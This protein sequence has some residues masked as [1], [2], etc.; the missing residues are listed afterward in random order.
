VP[1]PAFVRQI[2]THLPVPVRRRVLP[3]GW[4][5]YER[6]RSLGK[7]S[8]TT[9]PNALELGGWPLPPPRLRVLVVGETDVQLF[10]RGGKAHIEVMKGM[11]ESA[12]VSLTDE[13]EALDFGCGCGRM[14]RWWP[15]SF[16]AKLVGT[17][18]SPDLVAWCQAELPFLDASINQ[19]VPPLPFD[20][21]RFAYVYAL[22]VFTHLPREVEQGWLAEL[23]RVLRPGGHLFFSVSG[24]GFSER[25]S[26]EERDAYDAGQAIVHFPEGAGSNLCATYH[27][28]A[29]VRE[30]MTSGF[31]L[32][33]HI[34]GAA[35]ERRVRPGPLRQDAYLFR[36]V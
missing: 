10:L 26:E 11:L 24:E 6:W 29:Y 17:D 30:Q 1:A 36:R 33:S 31:E 2:A 4:R 18:L 12:G 16:S 9:E 15:D 21:E 28:P 32:V 19:L 22:S 20:A 35:R 23:R 13:D 14:A 5:A 34:P 8:D 27:P 3:L 7:S 25:L